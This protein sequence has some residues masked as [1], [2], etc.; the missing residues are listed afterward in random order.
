MMRRL[1]VRILAIGLLAFASA[2]LAP[3]QDGQQKRVAFIVGNS[4]YPSAGNLRNPVEDASAMQVALYRLN[5]DLVVGHDLTFNGF[6]EKLSEFKKKIKGADIALF[7]FAGHGVQ[8]G[9]KNYLIPSDIE[10]KGK[11]AADIVAR[12][13]LLDKILSDMG[14]LAKASVTFLDACREPAGDMRSVQDEPQG[15]WG[16]IKDGLARVNV[17]EAQNHFIGFA[18][19]PGKPA[20]DGTGKNSPFT[21][22]LV[23]H[24][25]MADVDIGHMFTFV[26]GDVLRATSKGQQPE[27]L[28]RLARPVYLNPKQS[29]GQ[30]VPG[31]AQVPGDDASAQELMLESDLWITIMHSDDPTDFVQYLQ[32]YPNG[33]YSRL[34]KQRLERL[35]SSAKLND[36]RPSSSEPLLQEDGF[37]SA[38]GVA[39]VGKDLP[40]EEAR[41]A[42][43]ALARAKAI[44]AKVPSP[45]ATVPNFVRSSSE[46]AE[47]LGY[48]NRGFTF[49]EVFKWQETGKEVRAE[50]RAKVWPFSRPEPERRLSGALE[51]SEIIS[52]K[53]FRLRIEARRNAAIGMY[54]W[55]ADGTMVRLYPDR[56]LKPVTVKAKEQVWFPREGDSYP[57]FV[58]EN[59]RGENRNHE[60]LIIVSGAASLPF[61]KL[62]PTVVG[63]TPQSGEALMDGQTFLSKLAEIADHELELLVLPYEVRAPR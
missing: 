3:A 30:N 17:E 39:R 11:A 52:G 56:T 54:V 46:A 26:R 16:L 10:V 13:V 23:N 45:Q 36:P 57:A 5:F 18:A 40:K 43:L 9:G 14:R 51:P 59:L 32:E 29:V 53:T 34:A 2:G 28:S 4:K 44:L 42:A 62:V 21:A 55:Q 24:I 38:T 63:E 19:G 7:F 1:V 47:Q 15:F 33:R 58:A 61:D 49:A 41:R 31:V 35:K 25:A 50:L 37:V 12:S 60:A 8:H 20:M 27:A 48:M 6:G 22:A